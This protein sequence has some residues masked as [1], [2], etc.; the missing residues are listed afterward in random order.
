MLVPSRKDG[1][2]FDIYGTA[3]QAIEERKHLKNCTLIRELELA[4]MLHVSQFLVMQLSASHKISMCCECDA[5][6]HTFV[7]LSLRPQT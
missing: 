4:P 1:R 7:I 5:R 3:T 6:L 2:T